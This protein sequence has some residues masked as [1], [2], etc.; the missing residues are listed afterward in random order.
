[1][2][3]SKTYG[4]CTSF[5]LN[6]WS[7]YSYSTPFGVLKMQRSASLDQVDGV[8]EVKHLSFQ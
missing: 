1:M 7:P 2:L 6:I 3:Y 5:F 4:L 8:L